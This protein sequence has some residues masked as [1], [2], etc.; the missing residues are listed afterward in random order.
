MNKVLW[1]PSV[2]RKAQSQMHRFMNETGNKNYSELHKWSVTKPDLFWNKIISFFN[3]K[4]EGE[5][6]PSYQDLNFDHYSWYPNA[7]LNFAENL[8][9][10]G[11]VEKT[12]INFVHESGQSRKYSYGELKKEV[13]KLAA[14][15]KGNF[16]EGDVLAAYMPHIPETVISM[17][18][19]T[20]LGGAFTSTSSDFGVEGVVDR[21]G[22]S[23]PKVLVAA[24][25]YMYNGKYFD[26]L[27]RIKELESK[28]TSLE[29]I[30]IVNFLG[31]EL[32]ITDL[33][34]GII[35]ED[36]LGK[37]EELVYTKVPFSNPLYVM[38]SSGTTG[39]PKCIL[40]SVGGTLLQH[41]KEL[42]LHTDL[43][44]SKNIFYFTTCGWMMW[45]WL[46]S[47]LAL[48]ATLTLYE[49]SPG[50]PSLGE[51]FKIIDREKINIFGTSPKFL[52]ALEDSGWKNESSF[53]SLDTLMSTG[54]PL[55]PEQFDFI[56]QNIKS[57]VQVTSI[58]GGTDIIGCFMLGN[59]ILPVRR[60]EIQCLGLGMDVTCF[61]DNGVE[62]LNK[63]GELVCKKSF[64]SRPISFL[65]DPNDQ[66]LKE[67]YFNKFTGVWHHG[68]FI[69]INPEG[70]VEVF[71]R[72]DA[73]L[74]PGG[75][76][77]GTSEIYRQT[78]Q[79]AYLA[80]SLCIGRQ[81][82]GEVEVILFV[83]LMEGEEL[84]TDRI[85]EIKAKIKKNTTPRHVPKEVFL[86]QDI[87]YTRSGKKMELAITRILNQKPLSN[88]EAVAN[89]ECLKEYQ[90]YI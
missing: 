63:E 23:K 85:L 6:E 70:G 40:H 48:G 72:S 88:I 25:G 21:F 38:Y 27:P 87:P 79:L 82:D 55:L 90:D 19:A 44:A 15:L 2:D 61:D 29:K 11:E 43:T 75:V 10:K 77:I 60:G 39:K 76:R 18:A 68:D 28:I 74:N 69:L 59:P 34:K 52:K 35:W 12:A 8:L 45:N 31:K 80:D 22:Q 89:P 57:D 13:S 50:F 81:R 37:E 42:G 58:C 78:E 3:L 7:K 32:D 64:P 9:E 41:V 84:S 53:K 56:Y 24:A 66:K 26:L 36:F 30:I 1:E 54:A 16:G 17:L 62:Q 20:S 71:G 83:K 46:I 67:A 51:F 65:D 4:L 5:L 14:S 47:G 86:V 49:G 33:S 73:T